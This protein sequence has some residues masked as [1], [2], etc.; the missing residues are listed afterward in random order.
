MSEQLKPR[1]IGTEMEYG[2]TPDDRRIITSSQIRNA[3]PNDVACFKQFLSN[4]AR[5]YNDME[6]KL[7]YAGPESL[8]ALETTATE[9]AG[10][11]IIFQVLTNLVQK[12]VI[13][14]HSF[15]KRVADDAGHT[16]GYHENYLVNAED[17]L[18]H[19][20]FRQYLLGHLATR[21]V[22]AGA[23]KLKRNSSS[24]YTVVPAQKMHDIERLEG[25]SSTADKSLLNTRQ[26]PYAASEKYARQHIICGDAN[27]SAAITFVK[28]ASTSLVLRLRESGIAEEEDMVLRSPL[29]AAH[30]IAS[31]TESNALFDV[32]KHG[33]QMRAV[34]YQDWLL[35]QCWKMA[36]R[37]ELP[38]DETLGLELWQRVIDD[39]VYQPDQA[40]RYIEW[41]AKAD[42]MAQQAARSPDESGIWDRVHR[43]DMA[44]DHLDPNIHI[45]N[46]WLGELAGAPSIDDLNIE[47]YTKTAPK[48]RARQRGKY[49]TKFCGLSSSD[50]ERAKVTWTEAS[51]PGNKPVTMMDPYKAA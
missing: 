41:M 15:N 37:I 10:Q 50:Y 7:E 16:W 39:I 12:K 51:R 36:E 46:R 1:I 44:W 26:K 28:L 20:V 19:N 27:I 38:D 47:H 4:G 11:A 42:L 49:V 32:G 24:I 9:F 22:F 25:A 17:H 29:A 14:P 3:I 2:Y 43:V 21:T 40:K 8:G 6:H 31:D 30:V 23:G 35:S 48:T 5:L 18:Q 34:E 45:G 33:K 13:P